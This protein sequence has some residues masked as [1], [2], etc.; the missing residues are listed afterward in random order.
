MIIDPSRFNLT[1]RETEIV[2]LLLDGKTSNEMAEKLNISRHT[3]DT[4]RRK[5]LKKTGL[6]NTHELMVTFFQLVKNTQR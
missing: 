2:Y 6:R 5:I 1:P 4:H 3:V